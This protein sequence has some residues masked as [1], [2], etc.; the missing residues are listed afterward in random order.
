MRA[1]PQSEQWNSSVTPPEKA[2]DHVLCRERHEAKC[3]MPSVTGRDNLPS[4][5]IVLTG[6]LAQPD[7]HTH[8]ISIRA[9]P[10]GSRILNNHCHTNGVPMTGSGLP[11]GSGQGEFWTILTLLQHIQV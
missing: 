2:R 1:G 9:K 7:T 4:S 10:V 3:G 11:N 8:D 5:F 6:C